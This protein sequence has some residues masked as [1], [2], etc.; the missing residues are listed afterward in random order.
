MG[1]FI[2]IELS[3]APE[4]RVFP[5]LFFFLTDEVTA[6]ARMHIAAPIQDYAGLLHL[7]SIVC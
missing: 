1:K 5:S 7:P 4:L 3:E 2:I 6:L